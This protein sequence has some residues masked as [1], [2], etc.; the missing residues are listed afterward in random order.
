MVDVDNLLHKTTLIIGDVNS[1]KSLYT[2]RIIQ[3]FI[4]NGIT[5]IAVVDLAPERIKE[6]GGK[7]LH[8]EHP[9]VLYTTTD[10]VAP[11]LTGK[12]QNEIWSLA[13]QNAAAIEKLFEEYLRTPRKHLFINDVTLYLHEGDMKRLDQ[14]LS[15]ASTCVINAYYGKTFDESPLTERE[16]DQ[17]K[18]LIKRC[19]VLIEL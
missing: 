5:D 6:I 15:S 13:E 14:V 10:I 1:G 9:G 2:F 12:G 4:R 3:S 7:M 18:Q 19:D 8:I 17:V 16:R 11:R